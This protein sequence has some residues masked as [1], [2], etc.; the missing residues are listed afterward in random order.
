ML[1]KITGAYYFIRFFLEPA[2][3][4]NAAQRKQASASALVVPMSKN[5]TGYPVMGSHFFKGE[6]IY[7]QSL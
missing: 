3:W 6:N 7:I 5:E 4:L 1:Y 2:V